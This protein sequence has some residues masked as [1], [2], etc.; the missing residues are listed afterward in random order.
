MGVCQAPVGSLGALTLASF[1]L[2]SSL[3]PS[4]K[5][6]GRNVDHVPPPL[7]RLLE[8]RQE[9]VDA[10]QGLQAQKEESKCIQI[11]NT[12]AEKTLLLGRTRMAALNLFQLVCQHQRRPPALDIEDTE[13]HLEQVRIPLYVTSSPLTVG[14]IMVPEIPPSLG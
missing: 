5:I 1:T 7:L 4:R 6:Q 2:T 12:A 8:K 10:D 11:Q 14:N 13:G 3:N 9:L